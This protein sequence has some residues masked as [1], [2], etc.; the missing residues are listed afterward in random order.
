MRDS[1]H[2]QIVHVDMDA[3]YASVEQVDNPELRG[4]PILVG[5]DPNGRGVVSTASYE[6]RPFG[7]RSAMPMKQAL[8]LCPHAIVIQPR[9]TRYVD[10]S[11]QI[12]DIFE[13]YTPLVEPLSIDEAFLD[14]TGSVK[15]FGDAVQ[16]AEEMRRKIRHSTGL[17]CSVG[18]AANK[19]V[20]K[21][22]SDI[23]KPNGLVVVAAEETQQFLDPLPVSRLWGVGKATLP[24]IKARGL[25]AFADVRRCTRETLGRQL[26][27]LGER[28]YDLV[29]GEDDRDV[30]PDRQAK[31]ISHES[32]FPTDVTDDDHLRHVLLG[33]ADQVARRLRRHGLTARTITIKLRTDEFSTFTRSHTISEPTNASGTIRTGVAHLFDDWRQEN[34]APLRLVGVAAS[35]LGGESTQQ[36]ELFPRGEDDLDKTMDAIRNRYGN[37]AISRATD[38]DKPS[39]DHER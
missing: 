14:V 3:F 19:F 21:L 27:E 26:G 33:Q 37:D 38:A 34:R 29:R 11:R 9:M 6:A 17:T 13:S 12:F 24:R 1:G 15:L 31:S 8:R 39:R 30:I 22:A 4:K 2:R 5:G 32:T 23:E 7:C 35:N 36:L 28:L 16:I 10:V 20:A 25:H 18:I